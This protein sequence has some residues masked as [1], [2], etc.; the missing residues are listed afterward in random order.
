MFII[1]SAGY[2]RWYVNAEANKVTCSG[3][4]SRGL[5]RINIEGVVAF[6]VS[7][8]AALQCLTISAFLI[9]L[10]CQALTN[11]SICFLADFASRFVIS[12]GMNLSHPE[13]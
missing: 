4:L 10:I 2:S 3:H 12:I 9:L 11:L 6:G 1:L 8:S 7:I 5:N 13:I